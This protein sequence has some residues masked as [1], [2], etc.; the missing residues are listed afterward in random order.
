MLNTRY[1]KCNCKCSKSSLWS[2]IIFPVAWGTFAELY[3]LK[4]TDSKNGLHNIPSR[5]G[6][7]QN[8]KKFLIKTVI[9][10]N[11]LNISYFGVQSSITPC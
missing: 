7:L 11:E 10:Y 2:K 6:F 5:I 8:K 4:V 9:Y 3:V 1:Q